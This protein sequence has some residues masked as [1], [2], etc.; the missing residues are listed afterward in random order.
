MTAQSSVSKSLSGLTA[1]NASLCVHDAIGPPFR[2]FEQPLL[3]RRQAFHQITHLSTVTQM[4]AR[5]NF[6]CSLN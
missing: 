6:L 3:R 4:S 1:V 2:Y 5:G